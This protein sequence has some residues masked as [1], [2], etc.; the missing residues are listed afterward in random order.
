MGHEWS[1]VRLDAIADA[2]RT[3]V[4]MNTTFDKAIVTNNR[5]WGFFGTIKNN[6]G[7]SDH[8]AGEAYALAGH[9]IVTTFEVSRETAVA[10]LDSTSGR[11]LADQ[12]DD[13]A[14]VEARLVSTLQKWR[15]AIIRD[16]GEAEDT[17]A[18][19]P[20]LRDLLK[21]MPAARHSQIRDA[22]YK[23]AEGLQALRRALQQA[24]TEAGGSTELLTEFNLAAR[25]DDMLGRS[26]LGKHV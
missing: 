8:Q 24:D 23:A 1:P 10:Y 22:Y 3:H 16:L 4:P 7:I 15:R 17:V 5:T 20:T 25:A 14:H 26:K 19:P 12:I 2:E 6:M 13:L 9:L 11:H 18:C 21:T